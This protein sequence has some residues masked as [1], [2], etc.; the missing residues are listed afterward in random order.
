MRKQV[1]D[2]MKVY[3]TTRWKRCTAVIAGLMMMTAFAIAQTEFK[4]FGP[5]GPAFWGRLDPAWTACGQGQ[6]QS[7]IDFGTEDLAQ[8]HERIHFNARPVQRGSR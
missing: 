5:N 1:S 7:P 6:V 8:Y 2:R 3:M 4:Y